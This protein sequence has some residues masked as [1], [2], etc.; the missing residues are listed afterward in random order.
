MEEIAFLLVRLGTHPGL[1]EQARKSNLQ[2]II[3]ARSWNLYETVIRHPKINL[4]GQDALGR[5]VLHNLISGRPI[6]R[7]SDLTDDSSVDINIQDCRG[8][9]PLHLAVGQSKIDFA[10]RR[11]CLALMAFDSIS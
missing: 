10:T 6:E 7:F 9:T 5:S 11:R 2:Y 8:V 3:E 4:D 1:S